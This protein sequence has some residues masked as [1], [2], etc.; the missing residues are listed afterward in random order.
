L[1]NQATRLA[2]SLAIPPGIVELTALVLNHV[3]RVVLEF[4]NEGFDSLLS[5][6]NQLW[7]AARWVE[8]DLD[9]EL[10]RGV[11]SSIDQ[12][13]RLLLSDHTR[14]TTAYEPHQVRHLKE[15]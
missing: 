13:G 9:G 7:G 3:R 5:R 8:L 6:V 11:F 15:I 2:D 1:N 10:R 14:A 12:E 4:E